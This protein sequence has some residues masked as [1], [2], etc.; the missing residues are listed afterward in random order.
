MVEAGRIDHAHHD[1][2]AYRALTE[3]IELSNA[4]ARTLEMVDLS[5]TLIVVTADHSHGLTISG[6]PSRG[7]DIL[8]LVDTADGADGLPYTTLNYTTGPQQYIKSDGT[9]VDLSTI[10]TTDPDFIQPSL[11]PGS[12]AAHTGE[13]VPIYA[14]GRR[15]NK[16][17]RAMGQGKIGRVILKALLVYRGA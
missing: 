7:N 14:I 11:V 2:N 16:L 9:R 6:Y 17:G 5:E 1:N 15:H 10:D 8:G 13:D 3:T 4:V 12:A